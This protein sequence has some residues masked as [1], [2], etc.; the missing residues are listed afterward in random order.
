M[1]YVWTKFA[2]M[3]TFSLFQSELE[4]LIANLVSETEAVKV[5]L[6]SVFSIEELCY[7]SVTGQTHKNK[8]VKKG[9]DLERRSL[10]EGIY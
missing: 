4:A 9:L 8:T 6:K 7:S 1:L 5:L 2:I 3:Y 10:V